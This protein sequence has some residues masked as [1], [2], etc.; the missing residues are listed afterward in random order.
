MAAD[1][2][3]PDPGRGPVDARDHDRDHDG[4]DAHA[5]NHDDVHMHGHGHGHAHGPMIDLDDPLVGSRRVKVVLWAAVALSAVLVVVGLVALWP[6]DRST[7]L[8]PLGLDAEPLKADV[9]TS[10]LTPC[11]YDPV[12][13]CRMIG[14]ELREGP[15][16][17][18]IRAIELDAGS[19]LR[20]GDGI[21]VL[22]FVDVEGVTQYSFYEF[23]RSTPMLLLFLVFAAAVLI[24]G[25]WR[26]LG[27]LAGLALSLMIIVWFTLP[28]LLSGNSTI[29]VAL[30][31]AG[32]IAFLTLFLAHGLTVSSAVALLS[33][34]MSLALIV[35]LGWLFVAA[36]KLT[37]LADDS[38][39]VLG[40]LGTSIDARGI[41]LAGLV[42]GA[43]GVL[44]DVTV[45]QVS[46]VWELRRARPDL[47][48]V[49]LYRPA[50]R[51]GRDHI[52]STVNTLFLA[53]AGAALPL[54][55]LFNEAAQSFSSVVTRELIAVEVVRALVGSIGLVA[56][57]PISTYLAAWVVTSVQR[58]GTDRP[59]AA[60]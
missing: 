32:V 50:L 4:A 39:L 14:F 38:S 47:T 7:G 40:A 58:T 27:A 60:A 23:Q 16:A 3:P 24:L 55:L 17:G 13:V 52:S 41:V 29:A 42:I 12:L 5:H 19:P 8:D 57:V 15:D 25:R 53:Y 2:P 18:Q 22:G 43:L 34:F 1:L 6:A 33:T 28:S 20:S 56:S 30:I 59:T 44:D 49:E 36:T 31:T 37:G 46:A 51:I 45:T 54:L 11:S 35:I 10:Q 48:T 26:G 21:F 9:V